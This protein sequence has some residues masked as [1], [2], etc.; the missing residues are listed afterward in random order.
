MQ[1]SDR[2]PAQAPRLAEGAAAAAARLAALARQP[3]RWRVA[4]SP[5]LAGAVAIAAVGLAAFLAPA[6]PLRDPDA[7]DVLTRL[8]APSASHPLGTDEVGRDVLA[9]LLYAGR[10]SLLVGIGVALLSVVAGTVLGA[11]AGYLGGWVDSVVMATTNAIQSFPLLVLVMV[12]GSIIT[13][14]PPR[15]VLLVAAVSWV[16]SARLVRAQVLSL[17]EQAFVEAARALGASPARIIFRHIVPNALGPVL[18]SAP[19]LVAFAILT[20]SALSFLG[21]GVRP[22]TATWGNMLH[23]AQSYIERAPWLGVF[24]GVAISLTVLS[25]NLVGDALREA[26]DPRARARS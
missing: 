8:T 9:R 15:L 10:I 1:A 17:R 25:F 19:I 11:L 7:V 23:A 3:R 18:V 6:L 20:E 14:D 5:A 24:P 13:L 2:A 21:F 26:L 22:P 16:T 4:P 12:V